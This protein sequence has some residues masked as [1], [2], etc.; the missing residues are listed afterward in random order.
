MSV[1]NGERYLK[2]AMDSVLRQTFKDF[3][4]IIINDGSTDNSKEII[5]SYKDERIILINQKNM[6][7][8]KSLNTGILHANGKYIARQDADD[9][10][11]PDRFQKQ[12]K[13][14]EKRIDI[15]LVGSSMMVMD[16]ASRII[17]THHVLLNN[18]ELKQELLVRSPFAH[19]SVMF[20]REEAIAAGLYNEEGWPA[21]D[22]DLWVR[23]AVYGKYA[24]IN[25][26]L[27]VYRENSAG[28]SSQNQSK[29][30]IKTKKLQ[31]FAWSIKNKLISAEKID[32]GAYQGLN[33]GQQRIIRII[34]NT[35]VIFR[36]ALKEKQLILALKAGLFIAKNTDS[37]RKVAGR[38]K[39]KLFTNEK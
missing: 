25:E 37:P 19:G 39:R 27:Y 29:Q 6:G 22:Y 9:V 28:I 16:E 38:F 14:L 5:E 36:K 1:Y 8:V 24:N 7:L 2:E 4:F 34:D 30:L 17:H 21:E 20:A 35:N 10:S 33:D 26:P 11:V 32:F 31:D 3:E 15:V 13:F 12:I 23:L 18:A